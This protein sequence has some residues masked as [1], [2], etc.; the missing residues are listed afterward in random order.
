MGIGAQTAPSRGSDTP[1]QDLQCGAV[2]GSAGM[3]R[4]QPPPRD[5]LAGSWLPTEASA[6]FAD[7]GH[8][9]KSASSKQGH[10]NQSCCLPALRS[11]TALPN[12]AS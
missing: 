12:E 6:I 9:A 7:Q 1:T 5:Q 2:R 11:Q 4:P 8:A 10:G 3:Q